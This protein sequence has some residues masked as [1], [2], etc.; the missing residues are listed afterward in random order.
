MCVC[1]CVS[2]RSWVTRWPPRR[3]RKVLQEARK[4]EVDRH[5]V[6]L[7]TCSCAASASLRDVNIRQIL[8]DEA[9]LASEP[10]TLIPLVSFSQVEKVS[11]AG[12][13]LEVQAEVTGCGLPP[14][15]QGLVEGSFLAG[16]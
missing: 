12:G 9:G 16:Q 7:C 8:V 15:T 5:R 11:E 14:G 1:V 13:E 3:Y 4:F 2:P 10:E 6:L